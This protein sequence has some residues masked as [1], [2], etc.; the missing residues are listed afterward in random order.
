LER[1]ELDVSEKYT[2][3][4]LRM[5]EKDKPENSRRRRILLVSKEYIAFLFKV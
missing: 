4:K 3:C 2:T 1:R 5:E